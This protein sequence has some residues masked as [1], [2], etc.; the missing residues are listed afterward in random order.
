MKHAEN[1]GHLFTG[2]HGKD[3]HDRMQM[4]AA[5]DDPADM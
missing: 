3:Y 2:E 5:A 4:N 1:T